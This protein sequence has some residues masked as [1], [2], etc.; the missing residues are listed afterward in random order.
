MSEQQQNHES[1]EPHSPEAP[2]GLAPTEKTTTPRARSRTS[3]PVCAA[4]R[5]TVSF[6][7][8]GKGGC[9]KTLVASLIAQSLKERGEPVVC[10]DTDPVNR[11]F[12]AIETLG[13]QPVR[14]VKGNKVDVDAMNAWSER[15]VAEDASFVVDNGAS[16]Y[17]PML[18]YLLEA[19]IF[20]CIAESGKRVIVHMPV[21]DGR[22]LAH[23]VD[24]LELAS[25]SLPPC[26]DIVPW[27]NPYFGPLVADDGAELDQTELYADMAVRLSGP[28]KLPTLHPDYAGAYFERMLD[29]NR[30][31]ADERADTAAGMISRMWLERTWKRIDEQI[32][33]VL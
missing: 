20:E 6:V 27:F 4:S 15:A 31:F 11:S 16:S 19:E 23:T 2:A 32:V 7:L 14:L 24:A 3:S 13:A 12:T 10:I 28:V 30:T 22:S 17:L 8:Q 21:I 1:T 33:Q 26:V 18:E 29:A 25:K 9:G 5:R